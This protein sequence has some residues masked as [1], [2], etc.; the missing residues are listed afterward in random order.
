[1]L[2]EKGYDI[3]NGAR[4]MKRAVQRLIEDKLASGII[5]E[6]IKPGDIV[7]ISAKDGEVDLNIKVGATV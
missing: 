4:P 1:L 5:T 6:M 7:E 2:V 3:E